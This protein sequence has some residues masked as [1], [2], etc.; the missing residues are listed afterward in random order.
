MQVIVPVVNA[1]VTRLWSEYFMRYEESYFAKP[2]H[3]ES[4][5]DDVL[6]KQGVYVCF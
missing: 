3:T 6:V 5:M 4:Y 1:R 2:S